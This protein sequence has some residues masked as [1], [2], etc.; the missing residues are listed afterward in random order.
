MADHKQNLIVMFVD[1]SGSTQLFSK[2]GD[3]RAL[4]LINTCIDK[5][6]SIV[7]RE[8]GTVVNTFGD[9]IL[10]TFASADSAFQ[11]ALD[12]CR[13]EH[14]Q[15]VFIHGGVHYGSVIA[16]SDS[17]YGDAVNIA[18]RLADKA[19][20]EE[21]ILS[22]DV[23][24]N[25]SPPFRERTRRLR[26]RTFLKGKNEPMRLYKIISDGVND[27]TAL[28]SH[29]DLPMLRGIQLN[30]VYRGQEVNLK[31]LSSD[32]ALGRLDECDMVI[33]HKYASRRHATI[34]CKP[35]KF[36]L[37]DHSSNGSY[38]QDEHNKLIALNR[39]SMQLHGS[40]VISLGI[41]PARNPE[42]TI[43]FR[44]FSKS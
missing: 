38:V 9:G 1:I 37:S 26:N 17:I 42:H 28:M 30:L 31:E 25:L 16:Q 6:K 23:M 5:L 19:K 43:A 4:Q 7:A 41:E 8:H 2:H 40:G 10:C 27:A 15:E 29:I 34:D 44:V 35:G 14:D 21:I 22:E 13:T 3:V 11:A 33:E 24:Q 18:S 20:K 36:T 32:F 39:D 12:F